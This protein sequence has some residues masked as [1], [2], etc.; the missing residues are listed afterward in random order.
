SWPQPVLAARSDPTGIIPAV[1]ARESIAGAR[2]YH[3]LAKLDLAAMG[4]DL[5]RPF[6]AAAGGQ[7]DRI[8]FLD[9]VA[10]G[11]KRMPHHGLRCEHRDNQNR[12]QVV[13]GRP[14]L[15]SKAIVVKNWDD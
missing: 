7:D 1:P 11:G 5:T 4:G 8:G 13:H 12:Q 10:N 6:V 3:D 2:A 15:L 9:G 14:S